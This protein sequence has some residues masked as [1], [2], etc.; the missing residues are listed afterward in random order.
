MDRE[1][2]LDE[3]TN[4]ND[5]ILFRNTPLWFDSFSKQGIQ[6]INDIWD[7]NL[8]NFI[9]NG[10]MMDKFVEKQSGVRLYNITK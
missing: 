4:G 9:N 7:E 6:N 1:S 3:H 2:V 5:R 8:N 10:C